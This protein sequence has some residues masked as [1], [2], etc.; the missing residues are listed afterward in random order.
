ME[1]ILEA[2]RAAD[3][4]E[5]VID[6]KERYVAQMQSYVNH[7]ESEKIKGNKVEKE[8]LKYK[9]ALLAAHREWNSA[10]QTHTELWHKYVAMFEN[11]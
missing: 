7:Y 11:K 2:R 3:M 6:K 5:L 1:A 10:L 8:L 4:A 9:L